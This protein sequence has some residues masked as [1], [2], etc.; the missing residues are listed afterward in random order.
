MKR[1]YLFLIAICLV[2]LTMSC[3][4]SPS[5]PDDCSIVFTV[6]FLDKNSG[7]DIV[8]RDTAGINFSKSLKIISYVKFGET[9]AVNEREMDVQRTFRD[10]FTYFS[11][12]SSAYDICAQS[13][14]SKPTEDKYIINYEKGGQSDSIVVR[15][16][17]IN[18]D[19]VTSYYLNGYLIETTRNTKAH[20]TNLRLSIDIR[21]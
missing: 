5:E 17:K 6:R 8:S 2:T 12:L 4:K 10:G 19:F 13:I 15:L 11:F 16:E 3:S 20:H 14:Y 18:T 7:E 1:Y 21:K 9:L